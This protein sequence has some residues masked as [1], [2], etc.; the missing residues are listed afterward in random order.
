MKLNSVITSCLL[1]T[2]T[3]LSLPPKIAEAQR[4]WVHWEVDNPLVICV[5]SENIVTSPSYIPGKKIVF[6]SQCVHPLKLA[7]RITD[8]TDNWVTLGWWTLHANQRLVL[9]SDVLD[10]RTRNARFYLYAESVDGS[11]YRHLGNYLS[12][13]GNRTLKMSE[14]RFSVD[15]DGDFTHT[16]DCS[17]RR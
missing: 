5:Q 17:I 4:C 1:S 15:A 16:I 9:A 6:K 14:Q 7:V 10:V 11:D 8:T 2:L 12:T 13:F 3:F